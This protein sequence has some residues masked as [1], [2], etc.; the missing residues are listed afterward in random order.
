MELLIIWWLSMVFFS[1]ASIA[2]IFQ[3]TFVACGEKFYHYAV[4]AWGTLV[5]FTR[6]VRDSAKRKGNDAVLLIAANYTSNFYES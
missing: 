1:H 6:D 2:E 4:L 3:L 5:R